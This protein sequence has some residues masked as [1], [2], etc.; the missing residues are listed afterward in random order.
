M[1][2]KRRE[3]STCTNAANVPKGGPAVMAGKRAHPG[4]SAQ[5]ARRRTAMEPGRDGREEARGH[6]VRRVEPTAMEPGR[7]GREEAVGCLRDRAGLPTA[8]EPGRDGREEGG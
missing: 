4:R 5:R 2:G 3:R 6:L 8:M 7:D 1:A